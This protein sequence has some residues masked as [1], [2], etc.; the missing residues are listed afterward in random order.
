[1]PKCPSSRRVLIADD[2]V[3]LWGAQKYLMRLAPFLRSAGYDTVLASP[4]G[5]DLW[6]AWRKGGGEVVPLL[7]DS[8]LRESAVTSTNVSRYAPRI[9]HLAKQ[10]VVMRRLIQTVEPDVVAMTGRVADVPTL[11]HLHEELPTRLLRHISVMAAT[12]AL[13]VS[14]SVA[15]SLHPS[16]R[17]RTETVRN[18]VDTALYAPGPRDDELRTTLATNPEAPIVAYLGRLDA[19]KQVDHLVRAMTEVAK[20]TDAQLLIM[21]APSGDKGYAETLRCD[22][23]RLL[24]DRVRFMSERPDVRDVLQ[25]VDAV[26]FTGRL[27]GLSLGLLEAM[28]TGRAVVAYRA[29]GVGEVVRDHENGLVVDM[30]DVKG[31]ASSLIEVLN[32]THLRVTLE[33]NARADAVRNHGIERQAAQNVAILD[34]LVERKHR[35]G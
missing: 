26:V 20:T 1:V 23:Q 28:S 15:D 33:G 7:D 19:A 8:H 16:A 12:A 22:A 13:S 11:L 3:G 5:G 18:G 10:V 9:Y 25:N 14:D 24:G 29:A 4:P 2:G 35:R 31:L 27:E 34:R 17:R 30:G 32:D 6:S 21:G